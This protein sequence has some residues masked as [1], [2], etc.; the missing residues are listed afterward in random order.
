[1]CYTGGPAVA[2]ADPAYGIQMH[3]PRFLEFIGAPESARLLFR[4]LAFWVQNMDREEAVV[5]A[6]NI[7]RDAGM[8]SSNLQIIGQFVTSLQRMS[9]EVLSLAMGPVVFPCSAVAALSPMSRTP[10]AAN[11]MSAMGLWR[12]LTGLGGT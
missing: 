4:S 2:D 3:H 9:A 6:I 11:Y 5:A 1:M 8:M 7:Q 10:R 12:P